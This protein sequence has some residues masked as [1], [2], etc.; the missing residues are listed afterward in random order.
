[1]PPQDLKNYQGTPFYILHLTYPC[2]YNTSG[3]FVDKP[4]DS[5]WRFDKRD[6]ADKPPP[7]NLEP[8]PAFVQNDLVRHIISMVNEATAAIPCWDEYVA[9]KKV[10]RDC[11]EAKAIS[12]AGAGAGKTVAR[13][14]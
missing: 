3:H 9:T 10:T 11:A 14:R 2:R 13:R 8:P 12:A 4:E 6:Y 5:V 1:M 7:R